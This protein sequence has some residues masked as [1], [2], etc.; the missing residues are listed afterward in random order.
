[1]LQPQTQSQFCPSY[2]SELLQLYSP[3]CSLTS[4][5]EAQ[6]THAQM[7][8]PIIF[9]FSQ[10]LVSMSGTIS[11]EM[12]GT[13]TLSS[14]KSKLKTNLCSP[15]I[16]V[17]QYRPLNLSVCT[18]CVCV[19]GNV[20]VCVCARARTVCTQ[21]VMFKLWLLCTLLLPVC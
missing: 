20:C 19:N 5:S 13:A 6:M 9:T 18:M 7:P 11:P 21:Y 4:F 17:K 8:A 14:F 3:S 15:N 10:P 16:V 2:L 12:P 1:M